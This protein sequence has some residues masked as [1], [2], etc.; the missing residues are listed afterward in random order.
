MNVCCMVLV[1]NFT[2]VGLLGGA[3]DATAPL[4]PVAIRAPMSM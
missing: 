4:I 1:L 3:G 2:V